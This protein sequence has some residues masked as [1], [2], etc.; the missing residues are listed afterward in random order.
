MSHMTAYTKMTAQERKD[1]YARV[2]AKFEEL[3]ARGLKLNMARGKPGP[4]QMSLAMG[5]L[6]MSDY[7]TAASPAKHSWTWCPM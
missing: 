4:H 1:E 7:T 5:L 2:S 3:K 6:Q